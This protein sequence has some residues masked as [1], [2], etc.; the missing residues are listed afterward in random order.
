MIQPKLVYSVAK[1][2]GEA[3]QTISEKLGSYQVTDGVLLKGNL[4]DVK[5]DTIYINREAAN[6]II[7]VD[8]KLK[9]EMLK[10]LK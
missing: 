2:Y 5:V 9:I 1:E 6:V 3:K 7:S 8:G 4:N 10:P